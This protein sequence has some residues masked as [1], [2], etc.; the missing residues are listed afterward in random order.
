L[1]GEPRA[2]GAT[3][4]GPVRDYSALV[5]AHERHQAVLLGLPVHADPFEAAAALLHAIVRLHPLEARNDVFGWLAAYTLLGLNDVTV[6]ATPEQAIELVRA[7]ER[8]DLDEEA[9][10]AQ[11]TAFSGGDR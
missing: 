7:A 9:I 5:A 6:K 10:A 3:R 11:L 4:I 2:E 8:G 1:A